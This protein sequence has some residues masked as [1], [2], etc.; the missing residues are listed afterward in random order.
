MPITAKSRP[1]A[2]LPPESGIGVA[3]R[4]LLLSLL[5]SLML[6]SCD[7]SAAPAASMYAVLQRSGALAEIDVGERRVTNIVPVAPVAEVRVG[8]VSPDGVALYVGSWEGVSVI[9]TQSNAVSRMIPLLR[10]PAGSWFLGPMAL[11]VDGSLLYVTSV[12]THRLDQKDT[13]TVVDTTTLATLAVIPV[14][15]R[16]SDIAVTRDGSVYVALGA[17]YAVWRIDP[18]TRQVTAKIRLSRPPLGLAASPDGAKVYVLTEGWPHASLD[19]IQTESSS[20]AASVSV[21]ASVQGLAVT[22]DGREI[23]ITDS[24]GHVSVVDTTIL[25]VVDTIEVASDAVG[26]IRVTP[27]GRFA[28]VGAVDTVDYRGVY[29][30][31]V[32]DLRTRRVVAALPA[33]RYP[34]MIAM[35]PALNRVYVAEA[36]SS[37]ADNAVSVID[38]ATHTPIGSVPSQLLY[39]KPVV[40]PAGDFAYFASVDHTGNSVLVLETASASLIDSIPLADTFQTLRGDAAGNYLYAIG[41]SIDVIDTRSRTVIARADLPQHADAAALTSD[42]KI[43]YT[44]GARSISDHPACLEQSLYATNTSGLSTIEFP[45]PGGGHGVDIAVTPDDRHVYVSRFPRR[46]KPDSC[47]REPTSDYC[48]CPPFRALVKVDVNEN[49]ATELEDAS[50]GLLA[51]HPNGRTLYVGTTSQAIQAIDTNSGRVTDSIP[52]LFYPDYLEFD[53]NGTQLYAGASYL[54]F[55]TVVDPWD[56]EVVD[57]I[58]VGAGVSDVTVTNESDAGCDGD[59]NRDGQVSV[60]ELLLSVSIILGAEPLRRCPDA[61]LD[62]SAEVALDE[63]ISAVNAAV[64]GCRGIGST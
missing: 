14:G 27:D 12:G 30:T 53:S 47:R 11:S 52:L 36:G 58:F 32:L 23:L 61:D 16:P 7:V 45:L 5:T 59:C 2:S 31:K 21:G 63:L 39:G 4:R 13:L 42:G 6:L 40:S 48:D 24:T 54:P 55:I 44:A 1:A 49:T 3:C 56:N 60:D 37:L 28:Y 35:N 38:T 18:S 57:T 33:Q 19:I 15:F 17:S 64:H 41:D 26:Q 10:E 62:R 25:E 9:D 20:V 22:P 50:P 46:L 34:V 43:L 29:Q 8:V 51:I